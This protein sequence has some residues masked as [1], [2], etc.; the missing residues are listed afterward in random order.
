VERLIFIISLSFYKK[1]NMKNLILTAAVVISIC[2]Q[3]TAQIFTVVP[4]AEVD[5]AKLKITYLQKFQMDSLNPRKRSEKMTLLVG[6][7]ISVFYSEASDVL[8]KASERYSTWD[9]FIAFTH[10]SGIRTPYD[11]Y[12]I[13]KYYKEKKISVVDHIPGDYYAYTEN[14]LFSWNITGITDTIS[15]YKAQMATTSFAGREWIAWFVTSI[16]YNEGPY[17]FN[18]LPGLIVK[19]HDTRNHYSFEML[20]VEVPTERIPIYVSEHSYIR[21]TKKD[22][23]RA[24]N[25]FR[26]GFLSESPS[27]ALTQHV[28]GEA[29]MRHNNPLELNP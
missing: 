12:R 3:S 9:E 23:F 20:S 16:P 15:G 26:N 10:T 28:V 25:S 8:E 17:K 11:R 5:R 6:N 7:N 19:V 29:L 1:K 14:F 21:T 22:F 27:D 24:W 4:K 2:C 13:F 18:G